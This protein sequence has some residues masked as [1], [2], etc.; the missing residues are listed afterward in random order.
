[1][2]L[3]WRQKWRHCPPPRPVYSHGI[4]IAK[5]RLPWG[6]NSYSLVMSHVMLHLPPSADRLI[7]L[8]F[9]TLTNLGTR[10]DPLFEF[11]LLGELL[12]WKSAIGTI[13]NEFP[14]LKICIQKNI[15]GIQ[16]NIFGIQKNRDLY[17]EQ[18]F[19]YSE[20]YLRYSEKYFW[21]SEKSWS[22]LKNNISYLVFRKI[23]TVFRKVSICVQ[24]NLDWYS[25]KSWL[26]FR[27]IFPAFRKVLNLYSEKSS[28]NRNVFLP[29]FKKMKMVIRKIMEIFRFCRIQ[30]LRNTVSRFNKLFSLFQK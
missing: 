5:T 27:K 12:S 23:S 4:I 24:K 20:K 22:V 14:A 25:E 13:F 3:L 19:W 8:K 16:K 26:V 1:M 2:T 15:C 11:W 17:W 10:R 30:I 6:S 29:V 7:W 9:C 18:Y 28:V 21:Y